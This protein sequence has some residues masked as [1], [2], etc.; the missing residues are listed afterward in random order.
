M[1]DDKKGSKMP[2]SL[3]A[4]HRTA[5]FDPP[6]TFETDHTDVSAFASAFD[7]VELTLAE[8]SDEQFEESR[9][10][11]LGILAHDLRSPLAAL[12]AAASVLE[13][14]GLTQRQAHYVARI[15]TVADRMKRMINELLEFSRGYCGSGIPIQ[16]E[17][18]D[19]GE[20]CRQLVEETALL[21]PKRSLALETEGG[22]QGAWDRD[23][24][25]EVVSNLLANALEHGEG[26]VRL[27]L[28]DDGDEVRLE[29]RNHGAPIPAEQ[30]PKIFEPFRRGDRSRQGLGLGLFIT[31]EIVRAHCG[32]IEVRSDTEETVFTVRWPRTE[33]AVSAPR[34]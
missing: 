7:L 2:T 27:G 10:R 31:R 17:P 14:D 25:A 21:H 1:N 15:Q 28:Y 29:V 8:A 13:Q 22:L 32:A 26:A 9:D 6:Y 23:R 11:F 19:M 12:I 33:R 18:L 3:A 20:L 5:K 34:L 4:L 30:L 16:R 24:L